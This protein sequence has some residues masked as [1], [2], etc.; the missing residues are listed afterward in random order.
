MATEKEDRNYL[1]LSDEEMM[2]MPEPSYEDAEE[3]EDDLEEEEE[4]TE[5]VEEEESDEDEEEQEF[6]EDN[7]SDEEDDSEEDDEEDDPPPR[8]VNEGAPPPKTKKTNK[9]TVDK[10]I[11]YEAEYKK[12]FTTFRANGR[13]VQVQDADQAIRL[14]QMG[15]GYNAKMASLKPSMKILKMLE[16]NG[17]LDEE[18][19]SYL[20]DLDKKN[21]EAVTKLIRDS[22]IDPLD[23]DVDEETEY[24]PNTY[25]VDDKQIELDVALAEIESS[26]SYS[27]TIDIIGNKWDDASKKALYEMPADIININNQVAS[28]IFKQIDDVVQHQ[29]MLGYLKGVSDIEAYR[30][31]GIHMQQQGLLNGT[32]Q[33]PY[34]NNSAAPVP[35]TRKDTNQNPKLKNRKKAASSTSSAPKTGNK[36]PIDFLAM[37]DEEF[38]KLA[39]PII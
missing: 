18:K 33:S 37:S 13:D 24:V 12:L 20:I 16:N 36:E 22:G 2:E 5:H 28:G 19:L 39:T 9:E 8:E 26:P 10:P 17:I 38:A 7:D 25:T 30:T 15:A 27:K 14:M 21:P 4:D 3:I 35:V 31:V 6:S 23:V 1:E 32:A 34:P 29:R 11:D